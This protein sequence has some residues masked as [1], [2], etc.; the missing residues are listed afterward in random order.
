MGCLIGLWGFGTLYASRLYYSNWFGEMVF[1]PF[2]ALIGLACVG[3]AIFGQD[4][5]NV[6]EADEHIK[7][8]HH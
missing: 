6:S 3:L 2:A 1:A 5:R 4:R 7:R 8:F